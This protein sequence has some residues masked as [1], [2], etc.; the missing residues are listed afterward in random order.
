MLF[1]AFKEVG[2]CEKCQASFS[3]LI[4]LYREFWPRSSWFTF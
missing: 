1:G 4:K 2:K 3:I